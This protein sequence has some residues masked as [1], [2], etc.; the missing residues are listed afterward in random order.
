MG[1]AEVDRF[2]ADQK[3]KCEGG[4]E[5]LLFKYLFNETKR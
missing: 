5:F 3:Y 4:L 2:L 1:E